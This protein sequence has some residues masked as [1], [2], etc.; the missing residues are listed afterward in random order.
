M[1]ALFV[2]TKKKSALDTWNADR[3]PAVEWLGL[4]LTKPMVQQVGDGNG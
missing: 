1:S 2:S 4:D 3:L